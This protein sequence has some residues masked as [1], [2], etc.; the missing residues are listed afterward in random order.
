MIKKGV[1]LML[2]RKILLLLLCTLLFSK[3]VSA[4]VPL[5]AAF[6]R[7][8]QLWVKQ[9]EQET[10]LT[11]SRYVYSPQ[12]SYDGRFIAYMDGDEQGE[13]NNLFIYDFISFAFI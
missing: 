4:E 7:D 9:G 3:V 5:T 2:G 10:Q 1:L 13:K 8:N 6:I 11:H 12:W